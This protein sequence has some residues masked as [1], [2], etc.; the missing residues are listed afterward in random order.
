MF[1]CKSTAKIVHLVETTKF[2]DIFHTIL[3]IT[4]SRCTTENHPKRHGH[5]LT[6]CHRIIDCQH[7]IKGNENMGTQASLQPPFYIIRELFSQKIVLI[8]YGKF[9]FRK[10]YYNLDFEVI[11]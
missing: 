10:F 9:L 4:S 1:I 2:L 7:R 3:P 11:Y 8:P 6:E 5:S